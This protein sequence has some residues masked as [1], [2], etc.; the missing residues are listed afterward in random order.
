MGLIVLLIILPFNSFIANLVKKRQVKQMALKDERIKKMNELLS[1]IKVSW[2]FDVLPNRYRP[3]FV[4]RFEAQKL[5]WSSAA[6][7]RTIS[8]NFEV[9]P[10]SLA[11]S[12]SEPV[13]L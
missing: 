1:G 7:W 8:G 9:A 10:P 5:E 11:L 12:E 13:K 6:I 4:A 2:G 3:F